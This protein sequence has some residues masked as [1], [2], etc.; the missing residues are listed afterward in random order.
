LPDFIYSP[1]TVAKACRNA[2]QN[3]ENGSE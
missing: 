2:S 1:I 3:D